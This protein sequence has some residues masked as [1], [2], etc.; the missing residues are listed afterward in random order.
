MENVY[1]VKRESITLSEQELGDA[2][3]E[4]HLRYFMSYQANLLKEME[5]FVERHPQHDRSK[6]GLSYTQTILHLS[7]DEMKQ[8]STELSELMERYLS[9]SPSE[10]RQAHTFAVISIPQ[11]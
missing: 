4:E 1:T 8:F 3:P 7:L 5:R 6:K 11:D 10:E 2:S 9:F